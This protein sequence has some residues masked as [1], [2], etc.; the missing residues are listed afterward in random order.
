MK[1][2][3]YAGD[4][5]H[6]GDEIAS[7][8]LDYA[9]ALAGARR[10]DTVVIPVRRGSGTLGS[11]ALLLGPASQIVAADTSEG[12]P[13]IED[14]AVVDDLR[15]RARALDS[16]TTAVFDG[17]PPVIVDPDEFDL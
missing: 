14:V 9:A 1:S 8:V 7:A 5:L 2:L 10:A 17:E 6:T 13:E 16:P 15:K 12:G 11:A 3:A 4:T